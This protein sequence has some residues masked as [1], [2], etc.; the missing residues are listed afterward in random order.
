MIDL[1]SSKWKNWNM[2]TK[3]MRNWLLIITLDRETLD[4]LNQELINQD[5]INTLVDT[6]STLDWHLIDTWSIPWLKL[7]RHFIDT[8]VDTQTTLSQHLS[9][10][11]VRGWVIF[12][13]CIWVDE[14]SANYQPAVDQV[15]P[16]YWLGYQL[17]LNRGALSTQDAKTLWGLVIVTSH[18]WW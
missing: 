11:L 4:W 13:W 8:L 12:T 5:L 18:F 2:C 17:T 16:G 7:D 6:W 9:Q 10:Q 15:L 14:H 3:G 1:N